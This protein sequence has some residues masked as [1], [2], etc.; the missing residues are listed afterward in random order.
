MIFKFDAPFKEREGLPIDEKPVFDFSA[1]NPK[2]SGLSKKL[3]IGYSDSVGIKSRA[4]K[5]PSSEHPT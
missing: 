1:L 2:K 3:K 5:V 4:S